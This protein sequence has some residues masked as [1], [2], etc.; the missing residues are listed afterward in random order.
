MTYAVVFWGGNDRTKNPSIQFF[1]YWDGNRN[2]T[3]AKV[4]QW[5]SAKRSVRACAGDG[6]GLCI[7][8][9]ATMPDGV[10]EDSLAVW[11]GVFETMA[12]DF[13]TWCDQ[14]PSD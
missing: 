6:N 5:N 10:T 3:L 1:A 14:A 11:A 8:M 4:N 13:T 7:A 2:I 12:E 9:D